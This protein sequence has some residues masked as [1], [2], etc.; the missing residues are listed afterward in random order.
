[1]T[2]IAQTMVRA[3]YYKAHHEVRAQKNEEAIWRNEFRTLPYI[4]RAAAAL[5]FLSKTPEWN[6]PSLTVSE[7]LRQH[8][9]NTAVFGRPQ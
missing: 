5:V 8:R 7:R 9:D 1:M 3:A 4:S 6:R 2:T